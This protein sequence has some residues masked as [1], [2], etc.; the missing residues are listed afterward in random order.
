M[1]GAQ[2]TPE[3]ITMAQ[4]LALAMRANREQPGEWLLGVAL[5]RMLDDGV[6][7]ATILALVQAVLLARASR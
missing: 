4:V 2:V 3:Q 5:G 7:V 6:E 1:E